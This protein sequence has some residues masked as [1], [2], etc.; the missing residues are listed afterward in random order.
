MA[1]LKDV[2]IGFIGG[3]NMAFAIGSGLLDRKMLRSDQITV[4]GPNLNNLKRWKDA[5]VSNLTTNNYE[6]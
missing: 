6:V 1:S 5:G 3:G 2:K 4:S